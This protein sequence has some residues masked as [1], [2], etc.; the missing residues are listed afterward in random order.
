MMKTQQ[1]KGLSA[2]PL[3]VVTGATRGIGRSIANRAAQAGYDIAFC[4]K[5]NQPAAE[6]LIDQIKSYGAD[7]LGLQVDVA[8]ETDVANFFTHINEHFGTIDVLINN[9]G[10]TGD[11][12]LATL[13]T[14]TIETVIQT[15]LLG[16][17]ICTREVLKYMLP[18]RQG[19]IVNISSVA[20]HHPNRGQSIYAAS[21][22]AVEAF[23]RAMAVEVAKKNIRVN[24]VSPGV[25]KTEMSHDLMQ[26]EE[27]IIKKMLAKTIADPE[28]IAN[29]V[30]FLVNP[31]N[32]YITGEVLHVDGGIKLG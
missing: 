4:F 27:Q 16:T 22:G 32:T 10:V 3:A 25:I 8:N 11:G 7:A 20:A 17:V 1:K 2:R 31:E 23:T 24:A 26:Y 5:S 15:N 30:M 14:K 29:A 18:K 6:A 13:E 21:K 9:A 19:S 12:L 28:Q